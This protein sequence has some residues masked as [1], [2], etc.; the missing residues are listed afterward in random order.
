MLAPVLE[1]LVGEPL[2][3]RQDLEQAMS[4]LEMDTTP[5]SVSDL[6]P[7]EERHII[8]ESLDKYYREQLDEPIPA[9]G[10]IT[11]RQAM[12]SEKGREKLVTWLK[13]LENHI[14]RHKPPEPMAGYD[15]TWLWEELRVTD[16]RA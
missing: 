13:R 9:L 10:D 8:H 7:E 14:A 3:E 16:L 4:E 1:G 6:A 2:V 11:P 12:K 5:G 15:T